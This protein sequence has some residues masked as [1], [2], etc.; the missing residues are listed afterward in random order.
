M[1]AP[2]AGRCALAAVALALAIGACGRKG[3]PVAPE[4]RVPHAV[5]DLDGAV[6]RNGR[7]GADLDRARAAAST[8]RD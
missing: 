6:L 2:A 3:P 8:T 7:R 4:R 5:H 1:T